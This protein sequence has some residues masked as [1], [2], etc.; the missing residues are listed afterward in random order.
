[1][2]FLVKYDC[3]IIDALILSTLLFFCLNFLFFPISLME[4]LAILD[5][6]LSSYVS[7]G[8]DGNLFFKDF[9]KSK[10]FLV[11]SVSLPFKS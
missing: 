10:V 2:F 4:S 9:I 3:N 1:M 5:V 11:A 6:Y 7:T 8:M